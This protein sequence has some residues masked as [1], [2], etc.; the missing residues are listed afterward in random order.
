MPSKRDRIRIRM[1]G[2][3]ADGGLVRLEDFAHLCDALRKCL[4]SL[5]SD[6][7]GST[8]AVQYRIAELDCKSAAVGIDAV[9]PAKHPNRG[10]ALARKFK[11]T[12]RHLQSNP[13]KVDPRID[14]DTLEQF[15]KLYRPV[16][17]SAG[18]KERRLHVAGVAL[19]ARFIA[20]IDKLIETPVRSLGSVS[21]QLERLNVHNSSEFY[22]WPP[23]H[24]AKVLCRFSEDLLPKVR[25]GVKRHVTVWG[26]LYYQSDR[27]YPI[28]AEV[29]D[30]EVHPEE[31][32]LPSLDD[33]FGIAAGSSG[34]SVSS[35]RA[36]RDERD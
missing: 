20:N 21:G 1:V 18:P 4:R 27:P 32:E 30:I 5:E 28:R 24:G 3:D 36:R 33:L 2:D 29:R 22:I 19:D 34:E 9:S 17:R 26:M 31:S 12:V 14:V 35:V 11:N 25:E 13:S 8:P 23:L 16:T 6:I 7:T 10:P 15:K